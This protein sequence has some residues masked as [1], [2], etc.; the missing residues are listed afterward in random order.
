MRKSG[1]NKRVISLNQR[2][3]AIIVTL[4]IITG[5]LSAYVFAD[6]E[7]T[8]DEGL[9][10]SQEQTAVVEEAPA[11]K[12]AEEPAPKADEE[13]APL[14]DKD[15]PKDAEHE[16]EVNQISIAPDTVSYDAPGDPGYPNNNTVTASLELTVGYTSGS[17]S[18]SATKPS[19]YN[20]IAYQWYSNTTASTS[21]GTRISRATSASYTIPQNLAAGTYYYYC[22]VTTKTRNTSSKSYTYAS[23]N[24][25]VVT[26][27]ALTPVSYT[28]PTGVTED[29][30]GS[31]I[32][33]VSAGSVTGGTMKYAVTSTTTTPAV[34]A[35]GTGVPQETNAGTYYVWYIV[36]P[37]STHTSTATA[38]SS[39]RRV[40]SK[41]NTVDTTFTAPS[42]SDRT[43]DG[44]VKPLVTGG[45]ATGGTLKYLSTTTSTV[46]TST[47]LFT[48]TV[49]TAR[50]AGTYYVWFIVEQDSNH[51]N[52]NAAPDSARCVVVTISKPDTTFTAPSAVNRTYDETAKALVTGGRATGGTLKY[53]ATTTKTVPTSTSQFTTT[54]PTATDAG[55]YYVWFIVDPDSNH[56]VNNAT[57][58]S[59][60]CV[61]VTVSKADT[62]FTPPTASGADYS[63]SAITLVTG[64][65]ATGGT[66]KYA[67]TTDTSTPKATAFETTVPSA[68]E[69]GTYYVWFIVDPDANHNDNNLRASE[70]RRIEVKINKVDTT[71]TAPT[72][73]ELTYDESAQ[74]LVVAGSATGGTIKYAVTTD[75]TA[76]GASDFGT[77][78]PTKTDAGTYYVWYI[79][80]PDANHN[81]NLAT[82]DSS[83]CI[84][85]E[86]AQAE[87]EYSDEGEPSAFT[88]GDE[89]ITD[90]GEII[91][92]GSEQALVA[93][94]STV[95]GTVL[96]SL[97]G[98]TWSSDVPTASEAGE[99][100]V[101][102]YI[103][104]D[105]N[106]S[107]S[108]VET[109]SVVIMKYEYVEGANSTWVN[110]STDP[111]EVR[112]SRS[113]EDALTL[114][115]CISVKIDD[116]DVPEEYLDKSSGSV[117]IKISA[118]YL[119]TLS[120]GEHTLVVGFVDPYEAT[121]KLTV[122]AA[123][124]PGPQT[125]DGA[126]MWMLMIAAATLTAGTF[127]FLKAWKK[128][129]ELG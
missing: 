127:I 67:V 2:F 58:D 120:V 21:G 116:Q 46:P 84:E 124:V 118:D 96:Y 32:E 40:Q 93:A 23:E 42:A 113:I 38:P 57:P 17:I 27:K 1:N 97:D 68:T 79:V 25:S 64:G 41:I 52:N 87:S 105:K 95:D 66:M 43:Y 13:A 12:A 35:F 128:D 9:A 28:D 75:T 15:P 63:G 56:N 4:G 99:Y 55:T 126:G 33:L 80:D 8:G 10:P 61:T 76:P 100:T 115:R 88:P 5:S 29:Y 77:S 69:A 18:S 14:V 7:D 31:A 103:K 102:F 98:T 78:V 81:D 30:S 104:G 117:I 90:L 37:D 45:S 83:R 74:S 49:P 44:T 107:D 34:S 16:G 85:V 121:T 59:T 47:R 119:K 111:V 86:I 36:E 11:P 65:S 125:G 82:P 60:K 6:D 22:V 129:E 92:D 3:L 123:D 94:G 73:N 101:S 26:V 89:G 20:Y 112:I 54:V 62:T 106:H 48:S 110:D 53:L 70:N 72:A 24:C 39:S 19:G 114:D 50:A 109:I 51:N 108:S 122:K 71:C 91:Y